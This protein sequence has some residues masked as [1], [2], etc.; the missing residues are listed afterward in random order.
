M[1]K[2]VPKTPLGPYPHAVLCGHVGNAPINNKIKITNSTVPNI[3]TPYFEINIVKPHHTEIP[4]YTKYLFEYK[5]E[6]MSLL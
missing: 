6:E 1:I 2:I 5:A 4:I 3:K